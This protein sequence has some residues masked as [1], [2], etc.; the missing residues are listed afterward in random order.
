MMVNSPRFFP[1]AFSRGGGQ[2]NGRQ[3]STSGPNGWLSA[4]GFGSRPGTG[5]NI[6]SYLYHYLSVSCPS[7]RCQTP[8]RQRGS[9]KGSAT[10]L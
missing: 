9:A 4:F 7:F 1:A 10:P 8:N 3:S 6:F 2:G 5:T